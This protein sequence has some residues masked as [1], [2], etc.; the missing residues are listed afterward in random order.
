MMTTSHPHAHFGFDFETITTPVIS[1]EEKEEEATT[2]HPVSE[3][4]IK[5]NMGKKKKVVN[6]KVSIKLGKKKVVSMSP[7]TLIGHISNTK[8]KAAARSAIRHQTAG[9][10]TSSKKR[11]R[12]GK[13]KTGKGKGKVATFIV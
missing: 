13:K 4:F 6:G 10:R 1:E 7:S 3:V 9:G 8:L 5:R 2:T 11:G 12:K